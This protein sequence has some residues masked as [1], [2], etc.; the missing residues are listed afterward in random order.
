VIPH[1]AEER[2]QRYLEHTEKYNAAIES[3]GDEPWHGG[4][5]EKR[6]ELFFRRWTRPGASAL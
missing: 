1:D 4:D 6:R 2:F 3:A 5:I